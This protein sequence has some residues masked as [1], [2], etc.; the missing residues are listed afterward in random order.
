MLALALAAGACASAAQPDTMP[1]PGGRSH[2][3]RPADLARQGPTGA[4][5]VTIGS[6]TLAVERYTRAAGRVT[7][8]VVSRS[9]RTVTRTYAMDLRPDGSVSR[10]EVT[11]TPIGGTTPPAV[12]TTEFTA[13]SAFTRFQRGDSVATS[14]V[15][16]SGRI[17]P[18]IGSS[19][20]PFELAMMQARAAGA[21]S[22]AFTLVAPGN[23]QTYPMKLTMT[24]DSAR[25]EYIAGLQLISTDARGTLLGLDGGR[26]TQKFI[27]TRVADVDLAAMTS[28]FARRDASGRGV[29]PL[30]P[31]DSAVAVVGAGRVAVD[32]GRP[33][34]RGRTIMGEVVPYGE[35]WRTGANAATGVTLTRDVEI[36]G[37]TVP[38]G[39]YTLWTIPGENG[40]KLIVNRQTGQ[41]GTEYDPEQDLARVDM[42]VRRTAEPVEKF[43]IVV[44]P[45]GGSAGVLRLS[46]DDT[47]AFV[48]FTVK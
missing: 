13:D 42:Q 47:E 11:S 5:V 6:D 2:P 28:D 37:A 7:G 25:I 27:V 8:T 9:P 32:Y 1:E 12:I 39:S 10:L 26:S 16:A 33:F 29:G 22:A 40:W 14:R 38:A 17:L 44:E 41:W 34:K 23:A 43:T 36:G 30:S 15:A 35:V 24:A 20:V 21:D 3:A 4:F 48:P 31:R 19:N 18:L 46:W 45:T